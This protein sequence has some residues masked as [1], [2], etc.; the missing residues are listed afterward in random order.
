VCK[1]LKLCELSLKGTQSLVVRPK[2]AWFFFFLLA[3]AF[4]SFSLSG[5]L[6]PSSKVSRGALGLLR[7]DGPG[8]VYRR[9]PDVLALSLRGVMS[10]N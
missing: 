2:A 3:F 8:R 7:C 4:S 1:S 9:Q 5:S 6:S 10:F